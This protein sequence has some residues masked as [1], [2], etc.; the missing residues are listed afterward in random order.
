MKKP[1]LF[2]PNEQ[3]FIKLKVILKLKSDDYIHRYIPVERGFTTLFS[4]LQNQ[5]LPQLFSRPFRL[6]CQLSCLPFPWGL[7]FDKL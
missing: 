6:F 2:M 1:T 5:R 3:P 7:L 4:F